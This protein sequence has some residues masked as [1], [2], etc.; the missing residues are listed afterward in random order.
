[1]IERPTAGELRATVGA[2]IDM[3]METDLGASEKR[4]VAIAL[5]DLGRRCESERRRRSLH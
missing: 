2:I 3:V 1:M 5:E 4:L